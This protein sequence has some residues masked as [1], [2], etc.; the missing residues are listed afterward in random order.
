MDASVVLILKFF[1]CYSFS[2]LEHHRY[3]LKGVYCCSPV[4]IT[5]FA[6]FLQNLIFNSQFFCL[7]DVS[8]ALQKALWICLR[9]FHSKRHFSKRSKRFCID[10]VAH[11]QDGSFQLKN[12]S[13]PC[14]LLCCF[15]SMNFI[16]IIS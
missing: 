2:L 14:R 3:K 10:V 7:A 15:L 4:K 5:F 16:F 12:I 6:K 1:A 11:K 9:Y 8:Q 13:I